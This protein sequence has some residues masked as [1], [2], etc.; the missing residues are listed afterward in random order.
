MRGFLGL[1]PIGSATV[2]ESP[3]LLETWLKD[4][5]QK[6][7]VQSI[8]PL[9]DSLLAGPQVVGEELTK[10]LLCDL[11]Q[12]NDRLAV[13]YLKGPDCPIGMPET[14]NVV[15][16]TVSLDVSETQN[17]GVSV[18]VSLDERGSVPVAAFP[19]TGLRLRTRSVFWEG[20]L[21]DC[22]TVGEFCWEVCQRKAFG[23]PHT[24]GRA[25]EMV[26]SMSYDPVCCLELGTSKF[27]YFPHIKYWY[28]MRNCKAKWNF[29]DFLDLPVYRVPKLRSWICRSHGTS[30][31][32]VSMACPGWRRA[33]SQKTE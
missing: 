14:Q 33:L 25:A 2:G 6:A 23:Y 13:E 7:G 1:A 17:F 12:R 22:R 19:V 15:S 9:T 8:F 31:S 5:L 18:S 4:D 26:T 28:E 29:K 16:A 10:I 27:K 30:R 32:T 21:V 3:P 11:Y 20:S 24:F